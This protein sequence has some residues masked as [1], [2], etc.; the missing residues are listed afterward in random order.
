[1]IATVEFER[2]VANACIFCVI[3]SEFSHWKEPSPIIL[4]VV[5]KNPE[6]G[7]HYTVLPLG[8][9]V[10]LREEGGE[11]LLFNLQKVA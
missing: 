5:D 6:I 7:F 2:Y 3:V 10:S 1:M 4:L 9:A 8:L 11:K